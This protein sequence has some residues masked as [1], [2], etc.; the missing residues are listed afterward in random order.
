MKINKNSVGGV[1]CVLRKGRNGE[2]RQV[3]HSVPGTPSYLEN[4]ILWIFRKH[5]LNTHLVECLNKTDLW[6]LN[7]NIEFVLIFC[8][9]PE[10]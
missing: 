3:Y 7:E 8:C 2:Y 1:K 6:T 5:R 10:V 4:N 9:Q